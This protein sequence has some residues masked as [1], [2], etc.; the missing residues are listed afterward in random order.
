MLS[1]KATR[2]KLARKSRIT[3]KKK[4]NFWLSIVHRNDM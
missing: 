2:Q 4:D 3:L 1:D